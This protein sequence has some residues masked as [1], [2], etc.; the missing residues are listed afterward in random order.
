MR[1]MDWVTFRTLNFSL[2][3]ILFYMLD[4]NYFDA[5]TMNVILGIEKGKEKNYELLKVNINE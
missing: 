5:K 4:C 1:E 2:L 3:T